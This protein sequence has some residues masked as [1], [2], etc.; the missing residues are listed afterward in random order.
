MTRTSIPKSITVTPYRRQQSQPGH[1]ETSRTACLT[2][3]TKANLWPEYINYRMNSFPAI[4][5]G[6][7]PHAGKTVLSYSLAQNL[8]KRKTFSSYL[9]HAAPDGEGNWSNEMDQSLVHDIRFKVNGA[10]PQNWIDV[11]CR[12]IAARSMPL[13]VDVGGKPT[14]EQEII[15]DQ[16]KYAILL[17]KDE[18]SSRQWRSLMHQHGVTIIAHLHSDLHGQN[19]LWPEVEGE[20]R[21][22]LAGLE[23]GQG[24]SGPAFE[25]VSNRLNNLFNYTESEIDDVC[26]ARAPDDSELVN[27]KQI[28]DNWYGS[29]NYWPIGDIQHLV[30]QAPSHTPIA[31]YGVKPIWL[32]AR[33]GWQRDLHWL[34]NAR[35]GWVSL[36]KLLMCEPNDDR[37]QHNPQLSI[38][39]VQHHLRP[40]HDRAAVA[41]VYSR[42]SFG[43]RKEFYYLD[44]A[45]MNGFF[46]PYFPPEARL[47]FYGALPNWFVAA[48]GQCYRHCQDVIG[49]Q[50]H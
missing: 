1:S 14:P 29:G 50:A 28:G 47:S 27:Y 24:A 18:Q 41:Q 38:N 45:S 4:L 32:A 46:V 19:Q 31:A 39:L 10:W 12:D 15:F 37:W 8:R 30:N 16:C 36:P 5:I 48:L 43:K 9:L 13:L 49:E 40:L 7:P 34:F 23:R 2:V 17:T 21:G 3:L 6:G 26:L 35:L 22:V 20:I 25:A 44:H 33:L 11:T 42:L